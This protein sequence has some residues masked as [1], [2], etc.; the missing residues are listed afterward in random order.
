[1]TTFVIFQ[2][3]E[4]RL[5]VYGSTAECLPSLDKWG[6]RVYLQCRNK[7]EEEGRKKRGRRMKR[8]RTGEEEE[9]Q[10]YS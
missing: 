9:E 1:M 2:T 6:L 8:G 10:S 7:Q 3:D 5:W 4:G